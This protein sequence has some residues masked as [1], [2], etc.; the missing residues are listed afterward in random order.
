MTTKRLDL[1]YAVKYKKR[2]HNKKYD[3]SNNIDYLAFKHQNPGVYV[4]QLDFLGKIKSDNNNILSFILPDLQLPIL[5]LIK[6]PNSSK[7]V[8]FFDKLE[9]TLG[10]EAFKELIP[11]IIFL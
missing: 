10:I 5:T 4:W 6:N 2:K 8:N 7:V 11:A 3:Y 9:E 1:P